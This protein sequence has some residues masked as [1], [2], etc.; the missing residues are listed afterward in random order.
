MKKVPMLAS[1]LGSNGTPFPFKR[2]GSGAFEV[3]FFLE[4]V[5]LASCDALPPLC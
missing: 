3:A 1:M 2:E 4:T 5:G